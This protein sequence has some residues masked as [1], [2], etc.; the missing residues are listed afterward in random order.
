[1]KVKKTFFKTF[2]G[3]EIESKLKIELPT[4]KMNLALNKGTFGLKS[5]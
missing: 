3:S 1:V 4:S 2:V 5:L